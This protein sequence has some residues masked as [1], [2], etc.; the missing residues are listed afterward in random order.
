MPLG[1]ETRPDTV[2]NCVDRLRLQIAE[3]FSLM[4]EGGE[5][6]KFQHERPSCNDVDVWTPRARS[7]KEAAGVR[8][9]PFATFS[10]HVHWRARGVPG[11]DPL[12]VSRK[13]CP[14]ESS[15]IKDLQPQNEGMLQ[16]IGWSATSR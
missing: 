6:Q 9:S 12:A 16:C 10:V 4:R 5:S 15:Q 8:C 13:G 3:N 1:A 14:W 11:L 7:N 2:F